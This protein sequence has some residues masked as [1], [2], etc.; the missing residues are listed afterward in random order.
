MSLP[1]WHA[2][3]LCDTHVN[4]TAIWSWDVARMRC[5]PIIEFHVK[6]WC[7]KYT[8][9]ACNTSQNQ[10]AKRKAGSYESGRIMMPSR[11]CIQLSRHSRYY[12]LFIACL[13]IITIERRSY[14]RVKDRQYNFWRCGASVT[15]IRRIDE[16]ANEN[17]NNDHLKWCDMSQCRHKL[18]NVPI[19]S[20]V[21]KLLT[22]A[23]L[24]WTVVR[25]GIWRMLA[26][27][28][29]VWDLKWLSV[30]FWIWF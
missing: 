22:A 2:R 15:T 27:D 26:L 9:N 29:E 1:R 19:N 28:F 6:R 16:I 17:T 30:V 14:G 20:V 11:L 5:D 12:Y 23:S 7:H 4:V 25:C 21:S 8:H 10:L 24:R 18:S 13:F 3:V